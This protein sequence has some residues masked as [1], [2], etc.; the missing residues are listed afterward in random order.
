MRNIATV[1]EML[2]S[3][4]CLTLGLTEAS[5][6][7]LLCR[8]GG[9]QY[10]DGST[11]GGGGPSFPFVRSA[12][13]GDAAA[14]AAHSTGSSPCRDGGGGGGAAGRFRRP[15]PNNF[16]PDVRG[17]G[18]GSNSL[19]VGAAGVAS[20]SGEFEI[21]CFRYFLSSN[22]VKKNASAFLFPPSLPSKHMHKG[23]NKKEV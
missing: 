7:S 21:L 9:G 18:G 15:I 11:G 6:L 2:T 12:A 20:S 23:H 4:I 13:N 8:Q 3:N 17:G 10:E 19:N 22:L 14:A 1:S 5:L 16:N